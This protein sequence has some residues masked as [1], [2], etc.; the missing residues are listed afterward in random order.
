MDKP[1]TVV[2]LRNVEDLAEAKHLRSAISQALAAA[3]INERTLRCAVWTFV[4]AERRASVSPA[5][6]ITRL[7]GLID[8]TGAGSPST[9]R[10]LTR[11]VI[12]WCV[13]EYFDASAATPLERHRMQR[14]RKSPTR[15]RRIVGR[16]ARRG[17][18]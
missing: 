8:A 13:E 3:P 5:Q 17:A 7:T 15:N 1:Q 16:Y 9:R 6:V 14:R 12:L 11:Q 10:A 4:G 18:Q 2:V